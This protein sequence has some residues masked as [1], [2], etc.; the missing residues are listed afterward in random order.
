[1]S[2]ISRCNGDVKTNNSH[3]SSFSY[4]A[5][6]DNFVEAAAKKNITLD[7]DFNFITKDGDSQIF[8]SFIH[9]NAQSDQPNQFKYCHHAKK[10]TFLKNDPKALANPEYFNH[11]KGISVTISSSHEPILHS[12]YVPTPAF[13]NLIGSDLEE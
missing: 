1:M 8:L 10:L 9:L 13:K 11:I 12:L 5:F 3:R 7:N 4:D 2:S 6:L